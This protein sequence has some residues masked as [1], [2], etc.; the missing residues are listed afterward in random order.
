MKIKREDIFQAGNQKRPYDHRLLAMAAL[1]Q[2][3]RS[4]I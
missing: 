4:A 3:E 1:M 2:V